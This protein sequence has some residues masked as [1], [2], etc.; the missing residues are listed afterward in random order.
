VSPRRGQIVMISSMA[1]LFFGVLMAFVRRAFVSMK[2]QRGERLK[3]A[4]IT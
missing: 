3:S 2:K 4:S 1:G